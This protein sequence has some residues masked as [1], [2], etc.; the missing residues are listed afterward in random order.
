MGGLGMEMCIGRF[1]DIFGDFNF[2]PLGSGCGDIV[3]C[4]M[5]LHTRY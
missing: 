2:V 3:Q 4:D 5:I 1:L